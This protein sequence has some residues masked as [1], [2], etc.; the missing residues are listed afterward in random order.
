MKKNKNF[1]NG[2]LSALKWG[3]MVVVSTAAFHARVRGLFHMFHGLGGLRKT[4]MFLPHPLVKL[5]IVESLC[6][7]E[8][9]CSASDLQCLYFESCVLRVVSSHSSHHLQEVLVCIYAQKWVEARFFS[10]STI[11]KYL[12]VSVLWTSANI[13]N[14]SLGTEHGYVMTQHPPPPPPDRLGR[15]WDCT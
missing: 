12:V 10:F 4:K 1:Y 7:R 2:V 14:V 5:S 6:G 9:A 15:L 8:V 11:D 3:P 13:E